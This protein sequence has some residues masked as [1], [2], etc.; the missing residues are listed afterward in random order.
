MVITPATVTGETTPSPNGI[1]ALD[2][3][4]TAFFSF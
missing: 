2:L 3:I 4:G 1:R